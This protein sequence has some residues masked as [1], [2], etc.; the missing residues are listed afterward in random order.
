MKQQPNLQRNPRVLL[1]HP[2]P[3]AEEGR[4]KTSTCHPAG[5]EPLTKDKITGSRQACP[6]KCVFL[7]PPPEDL[8]DP[9]AG[10]GSGRRERALFLA[11]L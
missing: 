11:S 3:G 6:G 8:Y 1:P 4:L 2:Q 7:L 9:D 10:K 5:G